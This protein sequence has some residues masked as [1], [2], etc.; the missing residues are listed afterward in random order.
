MAAIDK[1][2]KK[3]YCPLILPAPQKDINQNSTTALP[4]LKVSDLAVF[5]MDSEFEFGA[6]ILVGLKDHVFD[7][8]SLKDSIRPKGHF[9][10][11]AFKDISY[12]L[13]KN[14]ILEE[15]V[16]VVGYSDL[17][18]RELTVLDDWV[19]LF[20]HRFKIVGNLIV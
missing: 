12:A 16:Q 11:Y 2:W 15:D 13:T 9:S 6:R 10:I 19:S 17:S 8:T 4:L 3:K 7:V 18:A 5:S 14:S 20:R 1:A